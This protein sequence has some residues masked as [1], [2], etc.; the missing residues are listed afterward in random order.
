L[1]VTPVRGADW[2]QGRTARRIQVLWH[3]ARISEFSAK[4]ESHPG[5]QYP[6]VVFIVTSLPVSQFVC[7]SNGSANGS[8][9]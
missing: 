6:R 7:E 8:R 5:E 1:G 2:A 9:S 4:V 3:I